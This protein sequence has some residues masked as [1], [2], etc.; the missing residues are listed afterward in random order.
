[1]ESMREGMT[2]EQEIFNEL[3]NLA[4]CLDSKYKDELTLEILNVDWGD[5]RSAKPILDKYLNWLVNP[6]EF[7]I[8]SR[9]QTKRFLEKALSDQQYDFQEVVVDAEMAFDE[10]EQ[11]N[12]RKV[13]EA[14]YKYIC[15]NE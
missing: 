13:F 9:N 15:E 14:I 8:E 11:G 3:S 4:D 5:Y 2:E 6:I 10:T 1:M 12:P 7:P